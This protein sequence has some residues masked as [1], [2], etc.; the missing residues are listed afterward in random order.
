MELAYEL[1]D[2]S[3]SDPDLFAVGDGIGIGES[4]AI[5]VFGTDG[6]L[7]ANIALRDSSP[8]IALLGGTKIAA[9]MDDEL[10]LWDLA[11]CG[12]DKVVL[13]RKKGRMFITGEGSCDDCTSPP[14]GCL[15]ARSELSD[16]ESVRPLSLSDGSIGAQTTDGP[17]RVAPNGNK[18]WVTEVDGVGPMREVGDAVVFLSRDDDTKPAR[19]VAL[20]TSTGKA[21][22]QRALPT[23]SGDISYS[24]EPF[25]EVA[26]NWIVVGSKGKAAWLKVGAK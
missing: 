25:V 8:D 22:W 11:K 12:T 7:R 23:I 4:G 10:V 18:H 14:A 5:R 9:T 24:S 16:L 2:E 17:A 21:T 3:F 19:L 20:A 15:V 6:K 1:D 26:G 13:P